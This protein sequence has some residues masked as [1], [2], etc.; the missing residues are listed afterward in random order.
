MSLRLP[1]VGVTPNSTEARLPRPEARLSLLAV[2]FESQSPFIWYTNSRALANAAV[3]GGFVVGST[4]A[5]RGGEDALRRQPNRIGKHLRRGAS[6]VQEL[7][8]RLHSHA[9][10][11]NLSALGSGRRSVR[12]PRA[13]Q[14]V[15][16]TRRRRATRPVRPGRRRR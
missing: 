13:P 11:Q 3:R 4:V 15:G 9:A 8:A 2:C 5:V 10:H 6:T 1:A 12:T 14:P 16:L 7:A